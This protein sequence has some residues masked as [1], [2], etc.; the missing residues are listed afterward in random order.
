MKHD[1]ETVIVGAGIT[2]LVAAWFLARRS[3]DVCL[4]E[5][6]D[7]VGGLIR[8]TH[9]RGYLL[10]HGPFTVLPKSS[11]FRRLLAHASSELEVVEADLRAKARR[12]VVR[13]GKLIGIHG[14]LGPMTTRL[15]GPF[16]KL[17]LLR[18]LVWSRPATEADVSI[19]E[20]V[21]RRFGR[22]FAE[23]AVDPLI[24]GIVAGDIRELSLE[25]M[26]P[27][28]AAF[29][30]SIRSPLAAIARALAARRSSQGGMS[31]LTTER[32]NEWLPWPVDREADL[33][34]R[35]MISFRHG[36]QSLT[37]WL[38]RSLRSRLCLRAAVERIEQV[39]NGYRISVA[40]D[41]RDGKE[42]SRTIVCRKL[43]VTTPAEATS[44][45]LGDAVPHA[46]RILKELESA[47][48]AVVHLGFESKQVAR[49]PIGFGFLVPTKEQSVQVM[50][51]LF[52]SRTFPHHAPPGRLLVRVF[53]GGTSAP[54]MATGDPQ[55][56]AQMA[57]AEIRSLLGIRGEPELI[58]VDRFARTIPQYRV[59]HVEW[60]RGLESSLKGHDGLHLAGSFRD[61]VS[62]N[63]RIEA[64]F[65]AACWAAD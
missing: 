52:A 61:G 45:L 12:Y 7:R 63:D 21:T 59:G 16:A 22:A 46:A 19:A 1:C 14:R 8:T 57:C 48:L 40:P 27:Q 42:A 34:R 30:R 60:L 49:L 44:R 58:S 20:A 38:A 43:I 41:Q 39:E 54:E 15:Y 4:L 18:G 47:S 64:G 56:L 9:D 25:A 17:R 11:V 35:A 5:A 53:L 37:D 28:A 24:R 50:G 32:L 2:G 10:E 65:R 3:A 6:A 55:E 31:D 62:V 13:E 29:D 23:W 26:F 33:P 51:T 36:L